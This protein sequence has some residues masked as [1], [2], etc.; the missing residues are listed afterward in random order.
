MDG[1]A[2][3]L[4]PTDSPPEGDRP[5][6]TYYLR[7]TGGSTTVSTYFRKSDESATF[8]LTYDVADAAQRYSDTA[9]LYWQFIG[10]QWTVPVTDVS[11]T[12]KPPVALTKDQVKAW[13]HGPLTGVVSH[14]S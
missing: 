7:D 8:R 6:G 1:Q 12:I 14:R 13:A 2:R 3:P 5:P 11:I 9:E 4:S 10:D